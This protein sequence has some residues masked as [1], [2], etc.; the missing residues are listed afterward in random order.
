MTIDD[1]KDKGNDALIADLLNVLHSLE[2]NK[3]VEEAKKI[4]DNISD[5]WG[6][7]NTELILANNDKEGYIIDEDKEKGT[8]MLTA[9]R[10]HVGQE[11][12]NV[13]KRRSILDYILNYNLPPV[14]SKKYMKDWHLPGTLVRHKRLIRSL[15]PLINRAKKKRM[16][17]ALSAWTSDEEYLKKLLEDDTGDLFNDKP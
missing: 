6:R 1:I 11:G 7:R 16:T 10:Y 3:E 15:R 4:R 14:R 9:F 8:G 13:Q 5:E 17:V 12:L 2:E